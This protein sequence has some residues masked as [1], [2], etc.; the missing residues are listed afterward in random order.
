MTDVTLAT[1]ADADALSRFAEAAFVQTF[2][3]IYDPS[4][5]APTRRSSAI[6]SLVPSISICP[7]GSRR[8]ARPNSTS[9]MSPPKPKGRAL[10]RR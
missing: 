7:R 5:A 2:G 8:R 6:P 10:P 3:H 4:S 9:F 1:A